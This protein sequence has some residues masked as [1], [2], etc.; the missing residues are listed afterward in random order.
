MAHHHPHGAADGPTHKKMKLNRKVETFNRVK[1]RREA[2]A[3]IGQGHRE[4]VPR[5]QM[6]IAELAGN[7]VEDIGSWHEDFTDHHWLMA[8]A[9]LRSMMKMDVVCHRV[10]MINYSVDGQRG[11]D[12]LLMFLAH[13]GAWRG[14]WAADI[15]QTLK[16]IA[17]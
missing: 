17:S 11:R 16:R 1:R 2:E 12:I 7:V 5:P 10:S 15:K 14:D 3:R 9:A 13:A 4:F 6:T 8:L